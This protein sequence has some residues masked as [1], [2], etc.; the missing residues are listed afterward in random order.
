VDSSSQFKDLLERL[1]RSTEDNVTIAYQSSKQK[2]MAK[3]IKVDLADSVISALDA[4]DNNIWFEINPSSVNGRAMARDIERLAAVYIDI[5]YKDGGAGSVK[6]ARDFVQL[7][8]DVIGVGPT[9]T[10]YSGH[11][12]QP[13]WAIEDDHM[14]NAL[15]TGVLNR[16]GAFC[17]FLAAS[18]NIQ[19]DSVFDLPR[20]FRVPGSRNFKDAENPVPVVTVLHDNWRPITIDEINDVLVAHGI[21]GEAS[22][23]GEYELISGASE[24]EFAA[25]DCQFTPSLFAGVR[26]TNGAPKSRHGWLLQQLVLINASHRNGCITEATYEELFG[27]VSERFKYFLT[28]APK[29]EMHQG[30]IQ[31]ANKWAV[32]KVET[33]TSDKL[34]QELR[35][36]KHSDFFLGDPTSVLGEPS[37]NQDF[38][39]DQLVEVY[40]ASYGTYGRTDSAN[41]RRL[42]YFNQGHYKFVPDLGWF[43]W[44]GGRFVQDK[45]K[46]LYQA[47]IDAA[48]F[49]VQTPANDD[50]VKWAQ[51]SVNKD[52][53][54]NAITIAGTDPEVQVQALEMDSQPNDLCTPKGIVNLQTGEIREADRRVDLVT[55]QTT[56]SPSKV[57]TPLWDTFLK[58]V[59][60]DPERIAYL[61][62]LLGAS[63]FGDSRF[64]V[65]P[66]LVGS[67]ANG[68]STLLDVVAGILG[69]YAATMPENF[70]LDASNTTH[71]TEIARL[72]GVRFAMASETRPDGKFN[73][74]RVKMLTGG[75]TLSARFMNQNFFDFK[76]THTLFLAVNHL[77]AVK[78]G[79][80]GFWR[81]LRKIDF[82]ITIP[83][84]KRRENFAQLMVDKEGP[85]I[86]QWIVDGAVRVTTQGFNEPE[87][88]R[89][90]T[91][92]Y[93]HEEDHIAKFIDER[94]VLA[95]T[96][97]A[98]KTSVFNAYRDWCIDNGEKFITQNAI[99]REIRSRL[100]VGE[101]DTAGIRM[102]TGVEL[103]NLAMSTESI[104]EKEERDEYWR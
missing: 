67:G 18:Q 6:A 33:F 25:H 44:D 11:G 39:F 42:V 10:V 94:L 36:H 101:T 17:K 7:I 50:Q 28:L 46:A 96:G 87:S 86:L 61:Q 3:T 12:I 43:R 104:V 88:I 79:G 60:Q 35:R 27:L 1:G 89:L 95:A 53:I 76:P 41:A 5:D 92:T 29:R 14:D 81:R 83:S 48:E 75:D 37:A 77:P 38:D 2:F 99:A 21:S 84:E 98:T 23:P 90:A 52:R 24:W 57:D 31:G 32:A 72:R 47:A 34:E 82:N 56:V 102:F 58:D 22:M 8:T 30:E 71:P 26:P 73:E 4:L 49:I 97:T 100:N 40:R 91:L 16:W 80:D 45:E 9:A 13:Y 68:K 85:G 15:A 54:V 65:L 74:S 64:H 70:L 103:V 19:L 66:V 55:R 78:S 51:S 62:E 93:R 59:L 63:L 69:D 20:I